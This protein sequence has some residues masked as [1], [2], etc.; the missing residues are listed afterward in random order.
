MH[1]VLFA[2]SN[3]FQQNNEIHFEILVQ[4]VLL[5]NVVGHRHRRS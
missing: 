5:I 2:Q 1:G 3:V 4:A